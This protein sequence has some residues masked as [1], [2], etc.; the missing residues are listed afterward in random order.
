MQTNRGK[1]TNVSSSLIVNEPKVKSEDVL[2]EEDET[3]SVV[4]KRK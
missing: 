1:L 2:E 3:H 4:E